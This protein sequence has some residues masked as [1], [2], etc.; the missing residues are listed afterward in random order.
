[1]RRIMCY[2]FFVKKKVLPVTILILLLCVCALSGCVGI[3]RLARLETP[4]IS[5]EGGLSAVWQE[6]DGADSYSVK[7]EDI[8][9]ASVL[10]ET[11]TPETAFSLVDF[12]DEEKEQNVRVYVTALP[13]D[14]TRSKSDA[15]RCDITI[16]AVPDQAMV[17]YAAE[18]MPAAAELAGQITSPDYTYYPATDMDLTVTFAKEVRDVYP[19]GA[20]NY[21][22]ACT[23][24][25]SS[26]TLPKSYMQQFSVGACLQLK[27]VFA[28]GSTGTHSVF[29]V[30]TVAKLTAPVSTNS[31]LQ[32]GGEGYIVYGEREGR[33]VEFTF[34]SQ[35]TVQAVTLDGVSVSFTA[36]KDPNKQVVSAE[37]LKGLTTGVHYISLYTDLGAVTVPVIYAGAASCAPENAYMDVDAY[38]ESVYVRWDADFMPESYTVTINGEEYSSYDYP[39]RFTVNSFDVTGLVNVM[40]ERE[41]EVVITAYLPE[42]YGKSYSCSFTSGDY[43]AYREYIERK[44]SYMGEEYNFY[45][46][47]EDEWDVFVCYTA[48][49]YSDLQD[50][51]RNYVESSAFAYSY[52]YKTVSFALGFDGWTAADIRG[53]ASGN[54]RWGKYNEGL[55]QYREVVAYDVNRSSCTQIGDNI[56]TLILLHT[57]VQS[58][59]KN[60]AALDAKYTSRL[61]Q[62]YTASLPYA[63]Y[64]STGMEGDAFP[65]DEVEK[66]VSVSTSLELYFAAEAGLRPSPVPG[67]DAERIWNAARGVLKRITDERMS[68]YE[69]VH[70]I[71]DYLVIEVTYDN[72]VAEYSGDM[73]ATQD[74]YN[75]VYRYNSFF[76]EGVFDDKVAVCNGLS[77]AFVLL[78]AIEGIESVKIAGTVS[79]GNHAWNKV[80]IDGMWYIVDT[81]WGD[82][83]A[84]FNFT[85]CEW[86]RHDY[87]LVNQYSLEKGSSSVRHTEQEGVY[88]SDIYAGGV[89]YDPY[90]NMF[91]IDKEGVLHD[92]KADTYEELNAILSHYALEYT[93]PGEY[94]IFMEI[95]MPNVYFSQALWNSPSVIIPDG[96]EI[97]A[98]TQSAD[99]KAEIIMKREA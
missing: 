6:V 40:D 59:D 53:G 3:S 77:Q 27:A 94:V 49:Y 95:T 4:V 55:Q 11:T 52:P 18:V 12:A 30:D 36:A 96:F 20:F 84:T 71:Y 42:K 35:V 97:S 19:L 56:F 44:F 58:P 32:Y 74:K 23:I 99:T 33:D 5:S 78:C 9:S 45:I 21:N 1:M 86:N 62:S 38:P 8:S 16:P 64:S 31:N 26:V 46:T 91:Y 90:A 68:D 34:A 2:N 66:S 39:E 70:A 89:G 17:M 13:A 28:D 37:T 14:D 72:A 65:I 10:V 48:L 51:G 85:V 22:F 29:V 88:G 69:I 92:H 73:A 83:S 25:G 57:A 80:N 15:G 87:L 54:Y 82:A 47:D 63:H 41:E 61:R 75:D 93:A 43:S 81:T 98:I 76:M 60:Y 67:S 7:V 79:A 50:E 24:S